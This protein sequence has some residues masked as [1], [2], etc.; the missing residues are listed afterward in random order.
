[1][2]FDYG[3]FAAHDA[4][5]ESA[6][7]TAGDLSDRMGI[8]HRVY[9]ARALDVVPK[10]LEKFR[11]LGDLKTATVLTVIANDEV[12]HVSAGTR[13]FRYRCE[14]KG[15]DSDE[16]F[17]CLLKKYMNRYPKGPF[18]KEAR[19]KAGFSDHELAMLECNSGARCD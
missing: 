14:Q 13:W 1:M 16:L 18:N 15:V 6:I 7:K 12:N 17:F 10:T 3:D 11:A 5:W 4:L 9:E 8:L 2:G 19:L